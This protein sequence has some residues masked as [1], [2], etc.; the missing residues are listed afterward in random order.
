ML[1]PMDKEVPK[2]SLSNDLNQF[3]FCKHS[4]G[5]R[6]KW[7]KPNANSLAASFWH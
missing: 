2:S 7:K 6:E 4:E 3:E 1:D 5:E